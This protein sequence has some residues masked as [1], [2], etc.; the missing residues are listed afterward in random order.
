MQKLKENVGMLRIRCLFN[1]IREDQEI[2]VLGDEIGDFSFA[3]MAAHIEE[4]T[5]EVNR[6]G[7]P[8]RLTTN[9]R[10]PPRNHGPSF[11]TQP[12]T[13]QP[14]QLPKP[15]DGNIRMPYG[16]VLRSDA[17]WSLFK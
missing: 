12:G 3:D 8:G 7:G 9:Y 16:D 11:E 5:A 4:L 14:R 1:L 2:L 13:S 17:S 6:E 10:P 15:E